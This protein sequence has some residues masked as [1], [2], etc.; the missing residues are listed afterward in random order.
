MNK[1]FLG[2]EPTRAVVTKLFPKNKGRF[3]VCSFAPAAWLRGRNSCSL[4]HSDLTHKPAAYLTP[5]A[6]IYKTFWPWRPRRSSATKACPGISELHSGAN[7]W[8]WQSGVGGLVAPMLARKRGRRPANLP[9]CPLMSHPDLTLDLTTYLKPTQLTH[10][11]DFHFTRCSINQSLPWGEN[12]VPA[13]ASS[14]STDRN[15]SY[16]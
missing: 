8:E 11:G 1:Q 14:K 4:T 10:M 16:I 5:P 7:L 12:T 15:N 13:C 3:K 6:P 9:C 2:F